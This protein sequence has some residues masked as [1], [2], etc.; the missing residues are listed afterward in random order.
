MRLHPIGFLLISVILSVTPGG[1]RGQ[2]DLET[3]D[4]KIEDSQSR[5]RKL[6]EELRRDMEKINELLGKEKRLSSNIY[7]LEMEIDVLERHLRKVRT[8]SERLSDLIKATSDS[9]R[10]LQEDLSLRQEVFSKRLRAMYKYGKV[11]EVEVMLSSNS[12]PEFWRRYKFFTSLARYDRTELERIMREKREIDLKKAQLEAQREAKLKLERREAEQRDRLNA[13]RRQRQRALAAV[14]KSRKLRE[15]MLAEKEKEIKKLELAIERFMEDKRKTLAGMEVPELL[16][17]QGKLRWPASGPI[18][19][20]FGRQRDKELKT[21]TFN[22]GIDI[23]APAGAD[24]RAVASGQVVLV[25]WLRGYGKFILI[26]HGGGYFSLY[27]HLKDIFVLE[28]DPVREGDLLA[29]VGSTGSLDGP[30]LHFEIL[31]GREVQ[32][33]LLWLSRK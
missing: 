19:S 4:R 29:T 3:I 2:G 15:R 21:W 6:E 9:L 33:P 26:Y 12:F 27:G 22:R 28:G 1:P 16:A 10:R 14:R 23:G 13:K 30:K 5:I 24:V 31:K 32:D 17:R 25:G 8:E 7:R 20:R 18:L 11:R